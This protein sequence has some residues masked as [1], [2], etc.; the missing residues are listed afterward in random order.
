[1]TAS[2][3]DKLDAWRAICCLGVLWIHCWHLNGSIPISILGINIAKPLS[4]LGNGVDFFFVISGFCMYY[5]Y[6]NKLNT[7][8]FNIYKNFI[9][10]RFYRI[11]PAYIFALIIYLLFFFNQQGILKLFELLV[12]NIFLLQNFSTYLEVSSHFWSIAVEWHFY[13]IFP[14]ILYV[15]FYKRNFIAYSIFITAAIILIGIYLLMLN[16]NNDLQLPVRFVEFSSGIIMAYFYKFKNANVNKIHL[17][18]IFG[19]ILLFL[20]RYLNTDSILNFTSN[21]IY[22]AITKIFGYTFLAS[23]FAIVLFLTIDYRTNIF[24]FLKWE[25]LIFVGK[26]SY[27]FYLWHGLVL[28]FVNKFTTQ[29]FDFHNEHLII[30]FIL[31]FITSIIFT[32]PIAYITYYFIENKIK[33]KWV[34]IK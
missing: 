32:I 27:S 7:L 30:S 16:K 12:A 13:I 21:N 31:Q 25:P 11:M 34:G 1:M 10:S 5:F 15:N 17:K 4:V 19:F 3:L 33:Y 6:I 20:G 23:G 8:S 29:Y 14:L 24:N 2:R 26:I 22:Y 28:Y 18:L 9:L